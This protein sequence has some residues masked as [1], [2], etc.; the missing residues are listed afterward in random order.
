MAEDT[1]LLRN[2]RP[3]GGKTVDVLIRDGHI[4]SIGSNLP[5]A[6]DAP[7]IDGESAL[8]LPGLI[9]WSRCFTSALVRVHL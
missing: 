9:E 3:E 4:A 2:V 6:P 5:A 1:I 7:S 8:L